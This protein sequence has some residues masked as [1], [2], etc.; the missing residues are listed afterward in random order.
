MLLS[1]LVPISLFVSMEIVSFCQGALFINYDER[2]R[3]PVTGEFALARNTNLNEDLGMISYL[4][5]DKTGTLTCNDMRLRVLVL[6]GEL[7]G[8]VDFK[9][10]TC[11]LA[12]RAALRAFDHRLAD[13]LLGDDE[14]DATED[15]AGASDAAPDAA[16]RDDLK[17]AALEAMTAI[18]VCHTLI[19]DAAPEPAALTSDADAPLAVPPPGEARRPYTGPSP[20][21]VALVDG[22]RLLGAAFTARTSRSVRV[23]MLGTPLEFDILAVLEFTSE[24]QRMSVV[25]RRPDGRI[26]L[27]CKGADAVVLPLLAPAKTEREASV[28]ARTEASLHRLAGV[29]LRTLLVASR[30]MSEA[31]WASLD[32]QFQAEGGA[33]GSDWQAQVASQLEAGLSL[34]GATGVDD[35]LQEGVPDTIKL[36]LEAGIKVWIITGDKQETAITIG[37]STNLLSSPET[38]LLLNASTPAAAA[39]RM[40]ELQAAFVDHAASSPKGSDGP[41][42]V[43]DGGTLTHILA[44]ARLARTFAC[45]G[46]R[47]RAV[48][49]CRASPRQKSA[50][51]KLMQRHLHASDSRAHSWL[52]ASRWRRALRPLIGAPGGRTLAIG[53]GANDV[54][55]IQA[56]DVGVGVAGKEGRSALNNADYGISQFRFL[57]RLLLVHGTLCRYRLSRLIKYSFYKNICFAG[58]LF[59]FQF[60]SG[61]SGQALY[62]SI[63]A[64]LYN[65]VL[66]SAPVIAFSWFDRPLSDEALLA[67]PGLYNNSTSLSGRAFWKVLFDANVHSLACFFIPLYAVPTTGGP[68][69]NSLAGMREVGK[70]AFTAVLLTVSVEI[71]LVS[72]YVTA[73]FVILVIFSVLVWFPLLWVIPLFAVNLDEMIAM[74]PL[75]FSSAVFWLAVVLAAAAA[76]AYRLAWRALIWQIRPTDVDILAEQEVLKPAEQRDAA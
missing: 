37:A 32:A 58:L 52:H 31:E 57:S 76:L 7:L 4:F 71:V 24:R 69:G 40:Q 16:A 60:Y 47:A 26:T 61:F 21:E 75:L 20:D 14:S 6:G 28:R 18:A 38:A 74:A 23:D 68:R 42:L 46:A 19:V 1:Y 27:F 12:P 10:E 70:I 2:M 67:H 49:V 17:A 62:D 22:I 35:Q 45:L 29:G 51:V 59:W 13:A 73:L 3:D 43:V 39:Q 63:S 25:A 66:T 53:D 5:S 65:V 72:R 30:S 48:V 33:S 50:V 55:M 9:L 64:G 44:D 8:R 34:L 11:G 56:A 41:E 15:G 54:A 36:L